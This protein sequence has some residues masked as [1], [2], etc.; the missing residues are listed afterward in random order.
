M[1]LEESEEFLLYGI[2]GNPAYLGVYWCRTLIILSNSSA[3]WT[4]TRKLI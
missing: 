2:S 3:A 1:K 4:E